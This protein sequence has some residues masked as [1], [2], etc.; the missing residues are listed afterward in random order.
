MALRTR[1]DPIA[2]DIEL[3]IA[4]DLSPEA[5]SRALA[6]FAREQLADAQTT[7]EKALGRVPPHVT[8]VD[9]QQ[10]GDVDRV[11]PNG[12]VVFEFSLLEE[13]FEWIA[14]QLV[15]HAPQLTGRFADSFLFL[16]D[17][18]EVPTG[19]PAPEAGEYVFINT[20]PYA[21]KIERGLSDQAPDGVMEAVATLA[22]KR[23]GNLARIRFSF[24][25]LRGLD[26]PDDRQPAIVIT[27]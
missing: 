2:R 14:D 7:N 22:S 19:A 26:T 18:T 24:R 6:A 8:F 27:V 20:Q 10:G 21:R 23:F 17:G 5:Q 1:I 15:L 16:A 12:S 4:A 25:A 9:G 13:L 11:R 3:L